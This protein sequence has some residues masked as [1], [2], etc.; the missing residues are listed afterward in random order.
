MQLDPLNRELFGDNPDYE[1]EHFEDYVLIR[2]KISG[3]VLTVP[4]DPPRPTWFER[5]LAWIFG[6]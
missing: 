6:G 3:A 4:A 5:L 1:I 2:N